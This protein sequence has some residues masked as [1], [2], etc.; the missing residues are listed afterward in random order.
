MYKKLILLIF[1]IIMAF[2]TIYINKNSIYFGATESNT[3]KSQK[4]KSASHILNI[5]NPTECPCFDWIRDGLKTVE[6]RPYHEKYQ[7]FKIGDFL[8]FKCGN[9]HLNT[10]IVDIRP[11]ETLEQYLLN[12]GI[13]EVMPCTVT[14]QDAIKIYNKWSSEDD[15][16]KLFK[17]YKY[18]FMAIEI[19]II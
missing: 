10:K 6:G 19:Q 13:R 18:G 1:I 3:K 2:V 15:R 7:K 5:Q 12:E 4:N 9:D 17:K 16:N 14:M 11:Y 8:T